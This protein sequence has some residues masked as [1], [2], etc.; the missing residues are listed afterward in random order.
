MRKLLLVGKGTVEE[1]GDYES[2]YQHRD[3]GTEVAK[4]QLGISYL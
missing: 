1:P 2:R 4:F 3:K